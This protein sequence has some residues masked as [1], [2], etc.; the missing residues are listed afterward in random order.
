MIKLLERFK[1]HKILILVIIV[2]IILCIG[3]LIFSNIEQAKVEVLNSERYFEMPDRIV[4]KT[5]NQ[6]KYYVFNNEEENYSELINMLITCIDS[7]VEG[8]NLSEEQIKK[9]EEEENYI[10]LDY[11][12]ISKN[13][14]I[15]YQRQN[16]NVIKRTDNG[17]VVVK[18][19]IKRKSNL[20]ELINSKIQNMEY[21]QMSDN[22]EYKSQQGIIFTNNNTF[23]E[24]KRYE[25]GIYGIKFKNKD[26]LD[27]FIDL[28][29]IQI[30]EKIENEV[31]QK[32]EVIAMISKYE[33]ESINTRIGGITYNF[34]GNKNNETYN[35]D[36]FVASKAINTN[37]IYRKLPANSVAYENTIYDNYYTKNIKKF[38]EKEKKEKLESQ[39]EIS[40]QIRQIVNNKNSITLKCIVTTYYENDYNQSD[41]FEVD[42]IV[43]KNSQILSSKENQL[44]QLEKIKERGDTTWIK[45]RKDDLQKGKFVIEN[46]EVMGC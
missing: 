37:C 33:V 35:V 28:Y 36:L 1:E 16:Y 42:M 12:T 39:E 25:D 8:E 21:Y 41:T 15:A 9:I 6:D 14:V 43:D 2:T 27:K 10:E 4:Y 40:A 44:E 38:T 19:N 3:M 22:K 24:M 13:Y 32:A 17:G 31:F 46:L 7:I 23:P 18:S 26:D 11:N 29:N 20:E 5:K 30:N 34:T 45:L